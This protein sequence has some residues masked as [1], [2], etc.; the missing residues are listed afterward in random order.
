MPNNFVPV[1]DNSSVS[2]LRLLETVFLEASLQ[3]SLSPLVSRCKKSKAM[4]RFCFIFS[5]K[6]SLSS[7]AKENMQIKCH[8]FVSNRKPQALSCP[9]SKQNK[10]LLTET[11]SY[12]SQQRAL[13]G[14]SSSSSWSSSS[15]S[16][17]PPPPFLSSSSLLLLFLFFTLSD[18]EE[19]DM[20][21]ETI[22]S[23]KLLTFCPR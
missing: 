12:Q 18:S 19:T 8:F 22:L 21:Q 9:N 3:R 4:S 20:T 11:S 14:S 10:A 17:S 13:E 7:A 23:L 15:S 2:A 16:Y 1:E 5:T 6:S